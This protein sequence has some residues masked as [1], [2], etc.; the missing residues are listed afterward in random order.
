MLLG[1]AGL[2]ACS[3]LKESPPSSDL[4]DGSVAPDTNDATTDARSSDPPDGDVEAPLDA[5]DAAST[6]SPND[7]P[8]ALATDAW[9]K[10]SKPTAGCSDRR[11]F[12]LEA[13]T[14]PGSPVIARSVSIARSKSGR[15]GLAVNGET[16][17]EEG[18]L[19][20]RTFQPTSAT[21][22]NTLT[23]LDTPVFENVGAA[24]RLASGNDDTF[25]LVYQRDLSEGGGP[26]VYRRLPT[27]NVL[28][29]E[30]Q[31]VSLGHGTRLDIA[32]S[33]TTSAVVV[34]Y[35][36]P[37]TVAEPGKLESVIRPD[38]TQTFGVPAVIQ[39]S[40]SKDGAVGNGQHSL[41]IDSTGAVRVAYHL[42]QSPASSNPKYSELAGG[43][44]RQPK[45]VD[46]ATLSGITGYSVGLVLVGQKKVVAY[47][48]RKSGATS[49][50]LKIAAWTLET[51][52]PDYDVRDLGI[53]APD[54]T[55][56]QYTM[57]FA[58]DGYGLLHL[59]HTRPTSATRCSLTY[60]RQSRKAGVVRWL[61]D[62]I[63]DN[64]P[65]QDPTGIVLS[66]VV[67]DKGRP[68]VG[69]AVAGAGVYY[70]TRFDR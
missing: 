18:S 49:A 20:I 28:T 24:V 66:M 4:P 5:S 3:G 21:F 44:W 60:T 13:W 33:K 14:T 19:R 57:A 45:T 46:N 15:V 41:A 51:D 6:D 43:L 47:Y 37:P 70:A 11:V 39:G 36:T 55:S 30:Q 17:V 42:S 62:G 12:L 23:T 69:Y 48:D 1:L 54:P 32:V 59:V 31:V 63:A 50:E 56:P 35:Y 8:C 26:V 68:H 58:V 67:D 25:H 22:T 65:C 40:F 64:L 27:N 16:G 29:P 9:S 61:T 53:L 10:T 52:T 34:T 2:G 7:T 38:A